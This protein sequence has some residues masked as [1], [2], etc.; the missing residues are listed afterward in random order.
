MMP[1]DIEEEDVIEPEEDLDL[2][3]DNNYG[4]DDT[5]EEQDYDG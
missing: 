3:V 1:R 5:E 2:I 4:E